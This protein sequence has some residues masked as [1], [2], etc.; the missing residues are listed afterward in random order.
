M[1]TFTCCTVRCHE[2]VPHHIYGLSV[3]LGIQYRLVLTSCTLG[4]ALV[5]AEDLVIDDEKEE[6]FTSVHENERDLLEVTVY[7]LLVSPWSG[8]PDA[9]DVF[10]KH[11]PAQLLFTQKAWEAL[12]TAFP[13]K[14]KS[15]QTV[16]LAREIGRLMTWDGD[17]K[18]AVNAHFGKVGKIRNAFSYMDD[19]TGPSTTFFSPSFWLPSNPLS[20]APFTPRTTRS[21]T[22][23]TTTRT[24]LLRT[25]KPYVLADFGVARSDDRTHLTSPTPRAPRRAHQHQH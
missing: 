7:R 14:H 22:T 13:L 20:T 16:L 3:A 9:F 10:D 5:T 4:L 12:L 19:L 2:D 6:S 18:N 24:S 17:S 25:S 15:M 1:S 23:W 21:S 11:G 8:F